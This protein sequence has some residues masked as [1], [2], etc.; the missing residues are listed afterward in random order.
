M[1][2][3]VKLR[4]EQGLSQYAASEGIGIGRSAVK[5]YELGLR[6][7]GYDVLSKIA[8]FYGVS[9]DYLIGDED[10]PPTFYSANRRMLARLL[11]NVTEDE[12]GL[13]IRITKA[14]WFPEGDFD[15]EWMHEGW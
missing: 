3:L 11:E 6:Q 4:R 7:P 10:D 1:Q 15:R 13:L 2:R 5:N 8:K 12:V 14:I 9:V